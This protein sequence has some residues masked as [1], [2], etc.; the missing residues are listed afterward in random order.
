MVY[1]A[2]AGV[3]ADAGGVLGGVLYRL[4]ISARLPATNAENSREG[5]KKQQQRSLINHLAE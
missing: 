1:E 3:L 2:L 5:P 4:K